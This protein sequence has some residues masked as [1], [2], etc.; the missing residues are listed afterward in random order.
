MHQHFFKKMEQID[1][2]IRKA[3]D[4][5]QMMED[6]LQT[7]LDT[8]EADRSWLLFPCDPDA[9]S[10]RVPMECTRP[11]YPGAFSYG[12][13]IPMTLEMKNK[14][15]ELIKQNSVD[16]VDYRNKET[17]QNMAT[18]FSILTGMQSTI[19]PVIGK[20]WLFGVHQCSHYREWTKEDITF[21]RWIGS[22]LADALGSLLFYRNLQEREH[23]VR[24]LLN[25]TSEAILGID[26]NEKCTFANAAS[27]KLLGYS[28]VEELIGCQLNDTI[29]NP[30][31]A[32]HSSQI[33]RNI[34]RNTSLS[35]K[36]FHS[37]SISLRRANGSSFPVEYW[38]H[39]IYRNE[40]QTGAVVTFWDITERRRG[41][42]L[43][44][45]QAHYDSLTDLPNRLLSLDRLSQLICE[46]KR[47][48]N[49]IAVIF[50][51]L[52]DFRK[53]NDSLGH[54]V[55]DKLIIEAGNR[56]RNIVRGA[57]TVGRL[58]GDEFIIL[59]GG[60][61]KVDD[62][63]PIVENLLNC[64][65]A[66]FKINK[67]ELVLTASGGVSIYPNDGKSALELIR[68]AD[69]ALYHAKDEGRNTY[70]FFT[71]SMN[72]KVS[73]RLALEEQMHGALE[74]GEF[75]VF[76][77]VQVK[78]S[79]GQI[80][81]AEAL[82]RWINPTLGNITPTEFIPVAEQTGL[83]IQIGKFV[84]E[85]ALAKTAQ[86][87]K[88][89]NPTFRISV[90][91]SPCQFRD[92]KLLSF[93]TETIKKSNVS[94]KNILLEI[95]EGVFLSGYGNIKETL[96]AIH[97]LELTIAMDDFG[98]G[99]SSLSYLREYPFDELKIDRCFVSN[100]STNPSD[101]ALNDATIS[102]AHALN[103]QVVA[104]GIE[105]EEQLRCLK[106]LGCDIGQGYLFGKPVPADELLIQ[107]E[108]A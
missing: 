41:E 27:V 59:L 58:G 101:Y 18:S 55:G 44:L 97:E 49:L 68:N 57:D 34:D 90:N 104:E 50:L 103:L 24:D 65:R 7:T 89:C 3:S 51:D 36:A 73:R 52:D 4:I 102:M 107:L 61:K 30:P 11:E 14:F 29:F 38:S 84:F 22:R 8:L 83:I 85:E 48:D 78:F 82:L 72:L 91:L 60:L 80:I 45:Y 79:T 39:P 66:P 108:S 37:D 43:I 42:E 81:G 54:H 96:D 100:I 23:F 93:I 77:Q 32:D 13:E 19:Y 105:T 56:L 15:S 25:A 88:K 40:R 53:I 6:V 98:T 75:H 35:D 87:Q 9:D 92:P 46:V 67:R 94:E 17:P 33:H 74:R 47:T 26:L 5:E 70:S 10:W 69:S 63:I 64:V 2:A 31:L 12:E 99:Y 1:S 76:Y 86:W 21:F 20:P 95:T 71:Q 16:V 62:A 28:L 106:D